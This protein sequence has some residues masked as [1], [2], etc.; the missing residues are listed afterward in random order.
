[1]RSARSVSRRPRTCFMW[2]R[3]RPSTYV[4]SV[5]A[6]RGTLRRSR[7]SR[8]PCDAQGPVRRFLRGRPS[9][10]RD[11]RDRRA[12]RANAA[13]R[14]AART[15]RRRHVDARP[16]VRR[17]LAARPTP[18]RRA[19]RRRLVPAPRGDRAGRPARRDVLRRAPGRGK[20]RP[21]RPDDWEPEAGG[22]LRRDLTARRWPEDRLG[23]R[24]HP[25]HGD[26]D[27]QALVRPSHQRGADGRRE[28]PGRRGEA[29]S[30]GGAL[31]HRLMN[32]FDAYSWW[33]FLHVLGVLAFV[34]FHG[35]SAVVAFRLRKERDRT[36]IDELLQFSGTSIQGMY[37]SL[38]VLILFGVIAGFA[39]DWWRFWWIWI[40]LAL[41]VATPAGILCVGA[42]RN[43]QAKEAGQLRPSG[44][45]RRSDEGL[46]PVLRAGEA[47]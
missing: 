40:S 47:A 7:P 28:D 3:Y 9:R 30:P 37:V 15:P 41:L 29:P 21:Q 16:T 5:V 19:R 25:R 18:P 24:G 4:T 20:R 1:M 14:S 32:F 38:G 22:L 42:A 2:K 17:P 23:G 12:P 43:P 33:K 34:M 11:R 36:R 13:R 44:V 31:D 39:G 10:R 35:V 27:L 45:P 26:P 6:P 8:R 46:D